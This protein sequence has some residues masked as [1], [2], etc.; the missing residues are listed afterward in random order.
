MNGLGFFT[1]SLLLRKKSHSSTEMIDSGYIS[2]PALVF[3][4]EP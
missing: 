3:F 2:I 1:M 4:L